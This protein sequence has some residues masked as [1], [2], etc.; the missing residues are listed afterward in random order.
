MWRLVNLLAI[1]LFVGSAG[2]AYGVKYETILFAEQ[3]FK[4]KHQIVEEQDAISRLQAE[5]ALLTRPERLQ[6]LAEKNSTL[7]PLALNQIVGLN[8]LPNRPPKVD[9]IGRELMSL[10]LGQPTNTPTDRRSA[11]SAATPSSAR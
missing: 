9:S 2:Y 11:G 8:E 6:T 4:T 10:G 3:I 7:R 5:W 1:L